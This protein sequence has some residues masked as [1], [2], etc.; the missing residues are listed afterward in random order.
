VVPCPD[1]VFLGF[2]EERLTRFVLYD[3][4]PHEKMNP[5]RSE[6]AELRVG[7]LLQKANP[8]LLL[9]NASVQQAESHPAPDAAAN[10][11]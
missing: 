8:F 5:G 4:L 9:L 3:A 1:T 7:D 10:S 2:G 6:V 11:S